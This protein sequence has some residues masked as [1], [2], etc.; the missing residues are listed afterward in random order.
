MSLLCQALVTDE[1]SNEPSYIEAVLAMPEAEEHP[2]LQNLFFRSDR[3]LS[4]RLETLR[5]LFQNVAQLLTE[6]QMRG[7]SKTFAYRCAN[8]VLSTMHSSYEVSCL[9]G[10]RV[11]LDQMTNVLIQSCFFEQ[12][13]PIHMHVQRDDYSAFCNGVVALLKREAGRFMNE[14]TVPKLKVFPLKP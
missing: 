2:L 7:A 12:R 6:T 9:Q 13:I 4:S 5:K 8:V 11:C 10:G 14:K 3:F 1:I